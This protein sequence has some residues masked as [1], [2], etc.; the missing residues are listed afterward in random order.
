MPHGPIVKECG[1][2]IYDRSSFGR[3]FDSNKLLCYIPFPDMANTEQC[4]I[5]KCPRANCGFWPGYPHGEGPGN[6]QIQPPKA[7]DAS[8]NPF[9]QQVRDILFGVG[10]IKDPQILEE[11]A[12][13]ITALI[14]NPPKTPK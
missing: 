2:T 7:E 10:R 5:H 9:Q 8:I 6:Q 14:E 12:A 3:G 4:E 11:T 13:K 1:R